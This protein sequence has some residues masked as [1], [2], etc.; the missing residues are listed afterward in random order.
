MAPVVFSC[1]GWRVRS[2]FANGRGS[3][4]S[5]GRFRTRGS[6]RGGTCRA[7]APR[8]SVARRWR[9]SVRS[10]QALPPDHGFSEHPQHAAV[11]QSCSLTPAASPAF[12]AGPPIA[13]FFSLCGRIATWVEVIPPVCKAR[14]ASPVVVDPSVAIAK[15]VHGAMFSQTICRWPLHR[16]SRSVIS[17]E[18]LTLG[19][20]WRESLRGDA[21]RS[22]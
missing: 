6:R 12:C 9:P 16:P 22:A 11:A 10:S 18:H 5:G 19:W 13:W 4:S 3:Y 15:I 14:R 2:V 1:G 8:R 20:S 7:S 17:I 21:P